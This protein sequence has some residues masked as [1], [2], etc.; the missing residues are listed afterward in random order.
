MTASGWNFLQQ[1]EQIKVKNHKTNQEKILMIKFMLHKS[2]WLGI[3]VSFPANSTLDVIT[4][5]EQLSNFQE[6]RWLIGLITDLNNP[7]LIQYRHKNEDIWGKNNILRTDIKPKLYQ[8]Y[9][10]GM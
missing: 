6:L 7:E 8:K 5:F 3:F 10:F 2:S 4:M 9:T 1:Q